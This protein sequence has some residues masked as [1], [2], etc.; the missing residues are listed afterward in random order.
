[1][2]WCL[3]LG[4]MPPRAWHSGVR[5]AHEQDTEPL[6][7]SDMDGADELFDVSSE[8]PAPISPARSIQR[9]PNTT[10]A[11]G[12]AD[13]VWRCLMCDSTLSYAVGLDW[14]CA[15]CGH[16]SFYRGDRPTKQI[17][18]AGTW[19]FV[20]HADPSPSSSRRRRRRRGLAA[21]HDSPD[22]ST[23][24]DERAESEI[25]TQ[26]PLVDPDTP[27]NL[28]AAQQPN[29]SNV[30]G[31]QELLQALRQLVTEKDD[32]DRDEWS[33]AK[34]PKPGIKWKGGSAPNPPQWKYDKDDIR[35]YAKF[36][37]KVDI[38]K[39]QA[40][41]YMS[42]K[43]M[44]LSLYTS[45]QGE[46]EQEL[47]HLQ[48]TE[49]YRDDGV[50]VLLQCLK[51]PLEQKLVYQKR[52]FLHEFET[53][54]RQPGET[55]RAYL[56]RFRRSQRCLRSVGINISHTY[57]SE[58][59]GARLLDRSGL[60]AEAQRMLLVGTQQSLE[61]EV[62]AEA[63]L[64]QYPDFRG[65]PPVV[66]RDGNPT[67]GQS[68][69]RFSSNSSASGSSSASS[70]T[71]SSSMS[72]S[73][74]SG[75]G[76]GQRRNVFVSETVEKDDMPEEDD[77]S[78]LDTI[79]EDA[80][81]SNEI[82]EDEAAVENAN[83]DDEASEE[84]AGRI[85]GE[86]S[87]V[88][89]I[90]AK[91][92]AGVTLGRKF[93]T[94]RPKSSPN[95]RPPAK[96]IEER[97]RNSHCAVCGEKGH[98]QGDECRL[99][100]TASKSSSY[101][102]P[103]SQKSAM[104]PSVNHGGQ[105]QQQPRQSYVVNH[106]DGTFEIQ[107]QAA[108]FGNLFKC[109]VTFAVHEVKSGGPQNFAGLMILDSACQRTCCG[110]TWLEAHSKKLHQHFEV[111]PHRVACSELF[112]F[113]KG[114]PSEAHERAYIP[115][116]IAG[117]PMLVGSAVLQEDI[118]LL[119]SNTFMQFMGAI[120]NLPTNMVYFQSIGVSTPLLH[121]HGHFAIDILHFSHAKDLHAVWEEFSQPHIWRDPHP[122]CVLPAPLHSQVPCEEPTLSKSQPDASFSSTMACS[123]AS[124]GERSHHL[125]QGHRVEPH[126]SSELG[127]LPKQARP[128]NDSSATPRAS[129]QV[130]AREHQEVR[131]PARQV[132]SV[133][134][135]PAQVPMEC[136]SRSVGVQSIAGVIA[137]LTI[138]CSLMQQ[139]QTGSGNPQ[140]QIQAGWQGEIQ[141]TYE[142]NCNSFGLNIPDGAL[143]PGRGL[144]HQHG[145][146]SR[147]IDVYGP[148]DLR[149]RLHLPAGEPSRVGRDHSTRTRS[150]PPAAATFQQHA[151]RAGRSRRDLRLGDAR[152]L[153]GSL[154]TTIKELEAEKT[155][156][157]SLMTVR[158]RPPPHI[159]ILELFAG[160]SKLTLMAK[161]F[162]LNALEPMDLQHG[163][164]LCDLQVQ[165]QVHES[166][167]KFKPWLCMMGIDC[168]HYNW[169]NHNMNYA[170]REEEWQELQLED[171]P[172]LVF[173]GD[174]A[175]NQYK[176]NR[177]FIL[178]NPLRSQIWDD[179]ILQRL[180][181]LPG[182]WI[183]VL[184]T[185]AFGATIK[186]N[187]VCKSMKL[188]GNVPGLDSELSRRLDA[189]ERQLCTPIQGSLTRPSQEYPD[190]MVRT[191]LKVLKAEIRQREPQRFALRQVFA[192]ASPVTDLDAWKDIMDT[193]ADSFERSSK[194]P[195]LIDPTSQL[196][197]RISQL[198]R[199]DLVR[200]Q[201]VSTPTT[202]RM[203][204]NILLDITYRAAVLDFA[205][206]TRT[207]ELDS[208]ADMQFP[209]QRFAKTVKVALFMFG[210]MKEIKLPSDQDESKRPPHLPL[211]GLPTAISFPNLP[212]GI[213]A[214]SRKLT[215]RL[216]LNL[217]HPSKQEM[218]RMVS[219]YSNPPNTIIQC[220]QH[221]Q[222]STCLRLA[223][224]Q[225]PRPSTMPDF[226]VGQFADV[227]EGDVFFVRTMEGP[228]LPI[229]GLLDRA[230]GLHV[231]KALE[232]KDSSTVFDAILDLWLRPFGLPLRMIL[233]PDPSF[234]GDCQ[235]RL[236]SFGIEV[237]YCPAEAHWVI[238]AIERR[239]SI[240]RMILEKLIDQFV[241]FGLQQ[242]DQVI[243]LAMH[244]VNSSTW[245]RG[246][247]AFQA[248]F[249]RVP[250]LPCG[251]LTDPTSLS[252]SAGKWDERDNLQAKA[253]IIRSEAQRHLLDVNVSQRLRRALLRKTTKTKIPDLRPG[254]PCAFWRW[255]KKGLKKKGSWVISRF[256]AW[257]P[258]NP[259]K[260]AWVQTGTGTTLVTAEQL[261]AATGFESWQPSQ[262]DIKALKDA[263][264]SFTDYMLK[265]GD[266]EDEV[267]PEPQEEDEFQQLEDSEPPPVSLTVPATP[268]RN[269]LPPAPSTPTLPAPAVQQQV[270]QQVQ[271]H[272]QEQS[273]HL[274]I[275]IDSPT[276]RTSARHLTLNMP[277]QRHARAASRSPRARSSTS[278]KPLS[279]PSRSQPSQVPSLQLPPVRPDEQSHPADEGEVQEATASAAA[280]LH[281]QHLEE[282]L[283][284]EQQQQLNTSQQQT[285]QEDN[286]D[287]QPADEQPSAEAQPLTST[288]S[289]EQHQ[290][291]MQA[292]LEQSTPSMHD[293]SQQQPTTDEAEQPQLPD[294][295]RVKPRIHE[296]LIAFVIDDDFN[297][298]RVPHGHDGSPFLSYG[299]RSRRFHRAYLAS[300]TRKRDVKDS[301]KEP[302]ES[303][304]DA[305]SSGD[306]ANAAGE[307]DK[308]RLSRMERKALDR[309]LPWRNIMEMPPAFIDQFLGAIE[310]EHQS[311]LEWQSV[312]PLSKEEARSIL[313]DK[314]KKKRCLRSRAAYRDKNSGQGQLKAKC[315]IVALGHLD[316]DLKSL[317]RSSATPGRCTEHIVYLLMTA[318]LNRAINKDGKL[319]KCWLADAATAFLQGV[320]PDN[321]R[322]EPLYLI[323]PRDPLIAMTSCWM[324]ELYRVKGNIYGLS[325]APHLWSQ[326]VGK[327]LLALQY[328]KHHFDPSLF[329]KYAP[330][331][332]LISVILVYVDDFAGCF[333]EDYEINEV[334]NAF[335]WGDLKTIEVGKTYT[336][337]G[338][339]ICFFQHPSGEV[340][341]KITMTT[342][343]ENL[344]CGD[345]ARGRLA[346]QP[347]LSPAE[348]QECRSV[349]GCLQWVA[350]QARPEIA[351]TVS[352]CNHGGNTTISDLKCLYEAIEFLKET[353][354]DGIVLPC[355]PIDRDT[356]LLAYS[357]S[358]W[359]NARRST[360]QLGV[361][362][363]ATTAA[364]RTVGAPFSIV[365][366]KSAK[367]QRVCRST[368]AAEASA[369]DEAA[370]RL[371]FVNMFL[372]EILFDEPAHH[373]GCRLQ[374]AQAT[375]AKSLY[376]C[377]VSEAP[378]TTE[379]RSLVNIRAMQECLSPDQYHWVP[380]FLMKADGLTK[381]DRKL[382]DEFTQW[383]QDPV[384]ILSEQGVIDQKK[385]TSESLVADMSSNPLVHHT[386]VMH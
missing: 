161:G 26:D 119:A 208:L 23:V 151:G 28:V 373:V 109:M 283:T 67:K 271:Q 302:L 221:L 152:K 192:A 202:R 54:R 106:K 248:V 301:D 249:G 295:R 193:I 144:Q 329:L 191:I 206:G 225:N 229:L 197:G 223:P 328:R 304:S 280:L 293:D 20:P 5:E 37:K 253:E 210:V 101:R 378:T 262:E 381:M 352:L 175:M 97:K 234:R 79:P 379:K 350:T 203:P 102:P 52:R 122:E 113:G 266:L 252:T 247:S 275:N 214:E 7:P 87:Q 177:F 243:P 6:Q 90:T 333:R 200:I 361:L 186:G 138:A 77:V 30:S 60:S 338:K 182:V 383:L 212:A 201:A 254:E 94:T 348:Q 241:I 321:E 279:M 344:D 133:S 81:Q 142:H 363:G 340:R 284:V 180:Q 341:L 176:A 313:Q 351:P 239:N 121:V 89:T 34:G 69:G 209:R 3:L 265:D 251:L 103:S 80:E 33:S 123:V 250:R 50:D 227:V 154:R 220:I 82:P 296:T 141:R 185:G 287:Q 172:M 187:K 120:I 281:Q 128:C 105:S 71:A 100:K 311:W 47:E 196:G 380:T 342:F 273:T 117:V 274:N 99:S 188:I 258:A 331:G 314:I 132:R 143:Q 385:N 288:G 39:L 336:F 22:G 118:P 232:S 140:D 359:A 150:V 226:I 270:S 127:H 125:Q 194:Q 61:F 272:L 205:D 355:V 245:T 362:I 204:P 13:S 237:H 367:S 15:D 179:E 58:S 276:Y 10:N 267:G 278:R 59:L 70:T 366:W 330:D 235:T 73:R 158:Q 145:D 345:I 146:A 25:P 174:V 42:K 257:D 19:M 98:W 153:R 2:V 88:L 160:S 57:D 86:L 299:P 112:Q 360:S 268:A 259:L 327:R 139:Y 32:N 148:G 334:Y 218:M 36:C 255:S 108:E 17:T 65:P 332:S 368:L 318:G 135:V 43:D 277:P 335:K 4:V 48:V 16:G 1:M 126:E 286:M 173:S 183:V 233:D 326:E 92:L 346:K 136:G 49:F 306:D 320:Q 137:V 170:H 289:D 162:G 55:M 211:L 199:M 264:K 110:S 147:G 8:P 31:Q 323:P 44:A 263:E 111:R 374:Y 364:A 66:G 291:T 261:R 116:A 347:E 76:F 168:R 78:Q 181:D 12:S 365:D 149:D 384:A 115:S 75:K 285:E 163:H 382:R 84:D 189:H 310:R 290:T 93:T 375:D 190:E 317:T 11:R 104:Q 309:E 68:K 164:D 18:D 64:L 337:K 246:R 29:V 72:M 156:Y 213:P 238:G 169:F 303:D 260:R 40:S 308:P 269:L 159:D 184:D 316:P 307:T 130:Q 343:I 292:Q 195:Y 219:Y 386:Q 131:Q 124:H 282:P 322:K 129:K 21:G 222:C 83:D 370:D 157:D 298:H 171:R 297:I 353:P 166:I 14:M 294:D 107:D 356:M 63:M 217:G 45:L 305:D 134:S 167:A 315:R 339:Q 96:S 240:L 24:S 256:V 354:N 91:K 95:G 215:A 53:L 300:S 371:A 9:E 46:L 74:S 324:H 27:L 216:H 178:E 228:A 372:S 85:I 224:P 35:A 358:S 357:D 236:E 325:N 165:Q 369:G 319:W 242:M 244:A 231:A 230:T 51:Q 38:W 377:V 312:E 56:N 198:A 114:S 207:F 376:D 155:I 349:T 41:S 62:L